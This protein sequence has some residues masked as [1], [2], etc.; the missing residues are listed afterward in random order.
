MAKRYR[1]RELEKEYGDL[2][3]V[4][5]PLVNNS[6]Q[7]EAARSLKTSAATISNWLRDNGYIEKRTYVRKN[8]LEQA[9]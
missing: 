1:I 3:K 9:S 2:H 5:P 4:I 8:E 7:A 6:N